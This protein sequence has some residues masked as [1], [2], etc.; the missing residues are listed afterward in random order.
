[1]IGGDGI[2]LLLL[3]A[4]ALLLLNAAGKAVRDAAAASWVA[5]RDRQSFAGAPR[6]GFSPSRR[7]VAGV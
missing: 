5:P 1:V 4:V 6:T 7:A 2:D 3:K